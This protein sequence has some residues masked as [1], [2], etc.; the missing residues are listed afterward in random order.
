MKVADLFCGAGLFSAGFK[1]AGFDIV[2]G[3]D[4]NK[5]ACKTFGFNFP[6]A[7]VINEDI[8]DFTKF[9]QVDIII[10]SPPCLE[11]SV[12]N[13]DRGFEY[14]LVDRFLEIIEQL[15]PKYWVMENVVAMWQTIS[16]AASRRF[17]FQNIQIMKGSDYGA[18][19]VR[20]RFFGG[21]FPKVRNPRINRC[22]G[23]VIEIDRPG[24]RQPYKEYVYRKI[25]PDKPLFTLCSQRISNERYLLPNG[26]SL[27]ISEMAICQGV[28]NWFVF[29]VSRSEMQRQIGNSVCPPIAQAIAEAI[30]VNEGMG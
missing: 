1:D 19:T 4:N 20:R 24:F 25:D 3:I 15:A 16:F 21:K 12:G 28:P 26:T 7:D 13:T 18:A 5:N 22:V 9:P 27:T 6:E 17:R 2:F 8:K 30:K 23:D 29:P 14:E 11:F 10:G